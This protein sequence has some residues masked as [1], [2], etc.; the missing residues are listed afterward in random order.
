MC[1]GL[2]LAVGIPP[3]RSSMWRFW[4][5]FG[6]KTLCSLLV[7]LMIT[8]LVVASY[9]LSGRRSDLIQF[10][11]TSFSRDFP[12]TSNQSETERTK[13]STP[14][15]KGCTLNMTYTPPPVGISF[16]DRGEVHLTSRRI[17]TT[18]DLEQYEPHLF[19]VIPH[20]FLHSCRSPCWYQT[21]EGNASNDPYRTNAY[22]LYAKRLHNI[23]EDMRQRFWSRLAVRGG[24]YYRL[25]CLPH[26]YI[27]GQPKCGTTD[28]YDRLRLDPHVHF[29]VI[30]EPH[31]W[32]RK[33]FG[34]VRLKEPFRKPFPLEDY[35][36]L[37]DMAAQKIQDFHKEDLLLDSG[38]VDPILTGEASAS[39]LWD[40]SAWSFFYDSVTNTEPPVL[41][42][43]FI[44]A[45]QPDAKFIVMLRDPVERLY[46][47]YLYFAI[48]NKSA[49]DFNDKVNE[50]LQM[51]ESCLQ[52][53]SLRS[54]AYNTTFSNALPVRLQIGLYVVYLWDWLS[55]F[56]LDQ[57]LILRLEDH[58][59]N[60]TQSMGLVYRFLNLGPLS[61]EQEASVIHKQASNSRRPEDCNLGPM[62]PQT[63]QLLTHFYR[64]YNR[65]LA[66]VLADRAYMWET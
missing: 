14:V 36:D 55:V 15:G 58:A 60:I 44:H 32:T 13:D 4:R 18:S 31:W 37:F 48:A 30:K 20:Q 12:F 3:L 40:N 29:S 7:A 46:S 11:S 8:A 49:E 64:P 61:G 24:R 1:Q 43:D 19:S 50:S 39:T 62:L 28:L 10:L 45:F 25:R 21:Y 33:R 41:I 23:F 65:K 56:D 26:F 63:R 42:Q 52:A 34:I 35:L 6:R 9:A 16:P 59:A 51:F 5:N 66:E 57:F 17:P 54:C 38:R 2:K 22:S 27:I 47:D 53:S